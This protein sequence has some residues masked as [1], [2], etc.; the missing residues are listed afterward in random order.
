MAGPEQLHG[1][2]EQSAEKLGEAAQEQSER[3]HNRLEKVGELSPDNQ[4]EQIEKARSEASKEALMSKEAGREQYR[5]AHD[6]AAPAIQR[7]T[8]Q[9]K[10]Q[11]YT[12]TMNRVQTHL[13]APSRAFSKVIHAPIIEKTSDVAGKTIARPNAI[14][15]GG[16]SAFLLSGITY[17]LAR[18]FGYPLS[19]FET[20]GTFTLG[21]IIGIV[22]DFL[23]V[24][25]TGKK[26]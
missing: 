8:K 2:P 21:F 19:G 1:G 5:D 13:S 10:E 11:E 12:T 17:L 24:M 3:L 6:G 14:L 7:V 25:V 26:S 4:A 15:A 20:I 22:Y 18:T 9:Q 23:K 16:I